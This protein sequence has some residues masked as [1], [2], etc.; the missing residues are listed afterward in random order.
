M[1]RKKKADNDDFNRVNYAYRAIF[2]HRG[3][4]TRRQE[5][6]VH[7]YFSYWLHNPEFDSR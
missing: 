3:Y 4:R 6:A 2:V 1:D 5:H 7:L